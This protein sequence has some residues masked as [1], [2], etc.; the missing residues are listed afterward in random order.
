MRGI[1]E[2]RSVAHAVCSIALKV[3]GDTLILDLGLGGQLSYTLRSSPELIQP[4]LT[5][6]LLPKY[7]MKSRFPSSTQGLVDLYQGQ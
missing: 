3:V 5:Q 7:K 6:S 4:S 2:H 1:A